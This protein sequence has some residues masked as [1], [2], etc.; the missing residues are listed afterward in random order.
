[1]LALK[2]YRDTNP[3]F[4][5][6]LD[7][8]A[9][10]DDGVIMSK[11]GLLMAGWRY[12]AV[13][14]ASTTFPE[15][16]ALMA[17]LNQILTSLGSGWMMHCDAIRGDANEYP[18]ESASYFPDEIT[19]LIDRERRSYFQ[20]RGNT[21]E[22]EFV[23]VLSYLPPRIEQKRVVDMMFDDHQPKKGLKSHSEKI[24]SEFQ[25][26]ISLIESN[27]TSVV[28]SLERLNAWEQPSEDGSAAVMDGFLEHL[29]HCVTG[30]RHPVRL[31]PVPMYL[32]AVLGSK[33]FY[34]GVNPAVGNK[35]IAAVGIEGF[36][37]ESSP[38]VLNALTQ[39]ECEY[40]WSTRFIFLDSYQA[41][42]QIKR[43]RS[44]WEQK[45]HSLWDQVFRKGQPRRVDRDAVEM[46]GEADQAMS[47]ASSNL[48]SYGYYTSVVILMDEDRELLDRNC[49]AIAK[50]INDL[51]FTSR[52]EG[53][54]TIE[55]YLGSLP[56]HGFQNVRR[57]MI[58]TMNLSHLMPLSTVWSG[59]QYAPCDFYPPKS[60]ALAQCA[61]A[62]NTPFRLNL[63]VGDVG[64]TLILGPTGAGKST[65]LTFI[66]AQFRR[67]PNANIFAFDKNMSMFALC[68]ASGGQHYEIASDES[69]LNFC[70]LGFFLENN[71][72]AGAV[73]WLETVFKLQ[74]VAVGP[75]HGRQ[76]MEALEIMRD[77]GHKTLSDFQSSI[78]N[79]ELRE[80]IYA[81]T[82]AGP[83]G[84]LLDAEE[85]GLS[86][87]SFT[88]FE[89]EQLMQM[90]DKYLIPV[91]TYLFKRIEHRLNGQPS[92]I[93]LDEAWLMLGHPAFREKIREWLKVLRKANCLV[94]MATQNIKDAV[95]S[96]IL[97]VIKES[98]PTKIYLPN[99]VARD[100]D[101][102]KIYR[103][104]GLNNRQ[105]GLIASAIQKRQ[106]YLVSPEGAR[107]FELALGSVALAFCAVSDRE[108][109]E[110]IKKLM[111]QTAN[112][113][114][115]EYPAWTLE[116]MQ[117]KGVK[118]I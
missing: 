70:P 83:M 103:M 62:G 26:K 35:Y 45:V 80:A 97:D 9:V 40:R 68:E 24:I 61:T 57:P 16:N 31:P 17:R 14:M 41:E 12:R 13:D 55:A 34:P 47:E 53:L 48:V 75:A 49:K 67:Y 106:Y 85:D 18:A 39:L 76:I 33:D 95:D 15:V 64:H 6:L 94:V 3:G 22:T 96:G 30:Q 44:K 21:Y 54:N 19:R 113:E 82:I 50:R 43:Y 112:D 98:C 92:M 104:M 90:G 23:L 29:N 1:M 25:E 69:R 101:T 38:G 28:Q 100:E 84:T 91:L 71:N 109:I 88:V 79:E 105:I 117:S 66:E 93:V 78:Q 74:G 7:Y 114:S 65:L 86:A 111:A 37:M 73:E 8:A 87:S 72:L 51:G 102:A 2:Q 4:A 99:P 115:Y 36:P 63:H 108:S 118:I 11:S 10:V 110:K 116:W 42:A 77:N 46:V 32:D 52:I 58:N 60:P 27:L 107:M 81:Y 59:K 20:G 56:G 89:V 5:D